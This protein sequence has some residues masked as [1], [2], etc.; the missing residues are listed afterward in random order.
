MEMLASCVVY[1][2]KSTGKKKRR[3]GDADKRQVEWT[4]RVD[5]RRDQERG[6]CVSVCERERDV[7]R[8]ESLIDSRP[9]PNKQ[10]H[11]MISCDENATSFSPW[12]KQNADAPA[13]KKNT[14]SLLPSF[15]HFQSQGSHR[16]VQTECYRQPCMKTPRVVLA[17]IPL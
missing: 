10:Q 13:Q 12:L 1:M 15:P 17:S 2:T 8:Q 14:H 6:D 9:P 5:V 11:R 4:R 16:G 3:A 7:T